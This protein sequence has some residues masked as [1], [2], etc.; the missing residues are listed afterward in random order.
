VQLLVGLSVLLSVLR[1]PAL[2]SCTPKAVRR[3][4]G[5]CVCNDTARRIRDRE[6]F[7]GTCR[8]GYCYSA[9]CRDCGGE[10]FGMGPVACPCE[11]PRSMR[12][13]GMEQPGRWDLEKD[14]FVKCQV[15]LKPSIR[16]RRL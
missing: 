10:L 13:P 11:H 9:K 5:N 6:F 3:N 4:W 7:D 8:K 1:L 16:K 15:A 14:V 2:M 12:Y